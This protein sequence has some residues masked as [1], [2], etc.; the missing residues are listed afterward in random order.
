[1]F[2]NSFLLVQLFC[3]AGQSWRVPLHCVKPSCHIKLHGG[4]CLRYYL[5][6]LQGRYVILKFFPLAFTFVW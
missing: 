6:L 3:S 4:T 1:M 2:K 5:P